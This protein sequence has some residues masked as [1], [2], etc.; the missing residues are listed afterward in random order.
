VINVIRKNKNKEVLNMATY[1]MKFKGIPRK[2][3]AQLLAVILESE[4]SYKGAPSFNYTVADLNG[5][6]W[7]IT[8]GDELVIPAGAIYNKE[9]LEKLNNAL[10]DTEFCTEGCT[11]KVTLTMEEHTGATLRNLLNMVAG[12]ESMI[13]KA[14]GAETESRLDRD[15]II[16]VNH[17]RPE[18][19]ESFD[20]L[21][22][23]LPDNGT[24]PLL[25]FEN[26]KI[27]FNLFP[28]TLDAVEI[29]AY[30]LFAE[31]LS[32]KALVQ[33]NSYIKETVTENEKF[34]FR[35]FLLKLGFIGDEYK[36]ARKVLLRNLLGNCSFAT[37][38]S[39]QKALEKRKQKVA[40]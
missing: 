12:K 31:A 17:F 16:N 35:V 34:T 20:E 39:L 8:K 4:V 26:G 30:T 9:I 28:A 27:I 11:S 22:P 3:V 18:T 13:L 38:S 10:A 15:F 19:I 5:N 25:E 23:A 36:A 29:E 32:L 37:E 6:E 1:T 40:I 33:K 24:N 14:I 7:I 2:E 21:L